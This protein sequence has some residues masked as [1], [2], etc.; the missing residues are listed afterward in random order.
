MGQY[1]RSST[2]ARVMETTYIV[3]LGNNVNNGHVCKCKEILDDREKNGKVK[4]TNVRSCGRR[5]TM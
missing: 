5:M 4:K 3:N 1:G 2:N